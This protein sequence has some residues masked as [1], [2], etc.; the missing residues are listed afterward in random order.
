[1]YKKL[2]LITLLM[3]SILFFVSCGSSGGAAV[4]NSSEVI[5]TTGIAVDPYIFEAKFY[6]DSNKNG[7]YDTGEPI[8]SLSDE[9]GLFIFPTSMKKSDI[10][11]MLSTNKGKH[12]GVDYTGPSLEGVVENKL[13][14]GNV[15]FSPLTTLASKE[16]LTEEQIVVM[17]NTAFDDPNFITAADIYADPMDNI[18]SAT[19]DDDLKKLQ[20]AIAVNGLLDLI[21]NNT[22][23]KNIIDSDSSEVNIS[24]LADILKPI[25]ENIQTTLTTDNLDHMNGLITGIDDAPSFDMNTIVES[26]VTINEDLIQDIKTAVTSD[27]D[28]TT[29]K[30]TM[31]NT[32][33]G[34]Q[35]TIGTNIKKYAMANYIVENYSTLSADPTLKSNI[36]NAVNS[37]ISGTDLTEYFD[38]LKEDTIVAE[39][40]QFTLIYT[41]LA[42]GSITGTATQTVDSGNDG[43]AVLAV[44]DSGYDFLSWSDGSTDNPRTDTNITSNKNITA[45]FVATQTVQYT[46]A[47][48]AGEN[49]S[50]TGTKIQKV[51]SGSDGTSVLAVPDAGCRFI[52]WSDGSTDNPRTDTNVT[53]DKILIANFI[54]Q[55]ALTYTAGANGSITGTTTQMLDAGDDGTAITAT[56][57]AGYRFLSWSDG[58]TDNP[59]TDTDVNSDM[60]LTANFIQQFT[61]TYS[62]GVNGSIT[63]T[64]TQTVDSGGTGTAITAVGDS[65]S[66]SVTYRFKQWSDGSTDNPRTD[67]NVSSDITVSAEFVIDFAGGDGSSGNPYQVSTPKQLNNVRYYLNK[68][69][70]QTAN[71]DMTH[72]NLLSE[73]WYDSISGWTPIG[74][75]AAEFVGSYNGN[76]K[77]ISNLYINSNANN[78][79]GLFGKIEGSEIKDL[80]VIDANISGKNNVGGLVG[81]CASGYL[82]GCY[83]TGD[84]LAYANGGGLIGYILDNTTVIGCYSTM[85]IDVSDSIGGGFIGAFTGGTI[86]LCFSN[87]SITGGDVLGGFVGTMNL[88]TDI[89]KC[90]SMTTVDSSGTA[91]GF[92]NIVA[93]NITD[94]YAAGELS[95]SSVYGFNDYDTVAGNLTDCYFDAETTGVADPSKAG[96]TGL[97]TALMKQQS[98]FSGWDFTSIW[99]IDEISTY[100]YLLIQ[101]GSNKPIGTE[102]FAGGSG[103]LADPYQVAT[104]KQLDNVRYFLNKYFIQTADI[105]LDHATLSSKSWYDSTTGWLPIGNNESRFSGSYDGN[106]KTISNLH[107]STTV[108]TECIGLFGGISSSEFKD[109]G[110]IDSDITA[111]SC[112]YAGVLAAKSN[113]DSISNCYTTGSLTGSEGTGGF[114]GFIEGGSQITDC[115]T[116]VSVTCTSNTAGG[117]VSEVM[118]SDFIRC[119]SSGAVSGPNNIGGFASSISSVNCENCYTVSNVTS[120]TGIGGGFGAVSVQST[121]SNCYSAGSITATTPYG[122]SSDGTLNTA[123]NCYWDTDTSGTATSEIAGPTGMSTSDMKLEANF[124][125]WDFGSIWTTNGN[126]TY[127]EF[128]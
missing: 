125:G 115:Y 78:N 10:V 4:V 75:S 126:T 88:G 26:A 6:I 72:D 43:T 101:S 110:I 105:D 22:I 73:S 50:I 34:L 69:F 114:I 5:S 70:I 128:Q 112:S 9:D 45:I 85:S 21:E 63:G 29:I 36:V 95:G 65:P 121:F 1:L 119:Y 127:P 19:S 31:N 62:A 118:F 102:V 56:A 98:N 103:T 91:S 24:T 35:T 14:D 82:S 116:N 66:D 106:G 96:L 92:A 41:A 94:C 37:D 83:S 20:V 23:L 28:I 40:A 113:G 44:A 8:S 100:P 93:G 81:Y 47:Y 18:N 11:R 13:S 87:G 57:D 55:F 77:T 15:V 53:S 97:P 109:L 46:L 30:T 68:Y 80:G 51:D 17:I 27:S 58:S 104:A 124:A 33:T 42:N 52:S 60:N 86:S 16:S 76:G 74:D 67:I 90:Y 107:I 2:I 54:E 84:L 38:N 7:S 49:G 120:T 108:Y 99:S 111:N 89:E 117:F 3:I 64:T 71:I 12:N 123:T 122:F 79:I 39:T 25:A 61:L 48:S 32:I 59:R